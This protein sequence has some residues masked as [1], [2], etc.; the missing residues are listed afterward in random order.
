[1]YS[2]DMT[3]SRALDRIEKNIENIRQPQKLMN[4]AVRIV[5]A[6]GLPSKKHVDEIEKRLA[7][8][9]LDNIPQQQT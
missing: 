5:K 3:Q 7:N 8:L 1:M 2:F 6:L 9:K 4:K